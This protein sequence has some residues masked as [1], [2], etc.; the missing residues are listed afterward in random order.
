MKIKRLVALLLLGGVSQFAFSV[1]QAQSFDDF[2]P[3]VVKTVPE[4]GSMDVSPGEFEVK[5]TFSK[6][7]VDR[8]WS[9]CTVWDGSTPESLGKPYYTADHKTC[10]MKVKLEAGKCYG[11]WLNSESFRNFKDQ[12]LRPA[13]PYLL[14]FSTKGWMPGGTAQSAPTAPSN[15]TAGNTIESR[16]ARATSESSLGKREAELNQIERSI[17]SGDIP[18][19]LSFLAKNSEV[20]RHG[21]F[22][23]LAAKWGNENPVA[24]IAWATNLTDARIQRT[25]IVNIL[26]GWTDLSPEAAVAF[27]AT[28]PA[29]DLHDE[30]V[31]QVA[32]EW[33]FRDARG[34]AEWVSHFPK[35]PVRDKAIGPIIFWGQGQ[36]PA[37]VAEMLDTI[38]DTELIQ[39]NGETLASIWLRRD[40]IAA[41]AWIKKSP[42]SEEVKQRL[43]TT[44]E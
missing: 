12:Q 3:V 4:A 14:V 1:S 23:D 42:L 44:N 7:M 5:I 17:S 19:A 18:T 27:T 32:G 26:K 6:P 2:A 34:A 16:L 36:A 40:D 28:L 9:W 22:A 21:L 20:G 39:K 35:G 33:G 43:L 15:G 30:A 24:A 41:R 25:A 10:S 8:S 29:G 11:Y 13:V 31:V 38:G 37:A